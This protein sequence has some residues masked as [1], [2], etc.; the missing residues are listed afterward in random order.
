MEKPDQ[1]IP[2]IQRVRRVVLESTEN[3]LSSVEYFPKIHID[4]V[5]QKDPG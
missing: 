3:Q 5:S 1:S 2:T 4:E